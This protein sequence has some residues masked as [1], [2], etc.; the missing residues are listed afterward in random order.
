V[1]LNGAS[2]SADA[3]DY[4]VEDAVAPFFD[5]VDTNAFAEGVRDA[6][7]NAEDITVNGDLNAFQARRI[8]EVTNDGEK[9]YDIVDQALNIFN[10][11]E[12]AD[13]D[14]SEADSILQTGLGTPGNNNAKGTNGAVDTFE[15][16]GANL[17]TAVTVFSGTAGDGD[18]LDMSNL[19]GLLDVVS[20]NL[21][22]TAGTIYFL[23]TGVAGDA[24]SEASAA[25]ALM[26]AATW[27]DA[28]ATAYV[29]LADNNSTAVFEFVDTAASADGVVAGELST[30]GDINSVLVQA[31]VIV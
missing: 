24:D 28:D 11:I 23:S 22:T 30:I 5:T 16:G 21:T 9:S 13:A 4:D 12:L 31:D 26:D 8:S 14:F 7:N 25:A 27:T 18:K 6:L 20:G 17:E 19:G 3:N 10:A 15:Y 29:I 2:N 1:V